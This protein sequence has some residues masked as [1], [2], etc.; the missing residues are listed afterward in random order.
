MKLIVGLGNPGREYSNTR[1]NIGFRAVE[2]IVN[3]NSAWSE[4]KDYLVAESVLNNQK[5]MFIKPQ[6]Y[7]NNSGQPVSEVARFFKFDP[8]E[9]L[10]V[11]D[12]VDIPYG[13]IRIKEGGG[14][15]GHNG[16]KSVTQHLGSSE[17]LRLR[18][19]VGRPEI[20]EMD[21]AD[22]VLGRFSQEEGKILP[23]FLD[24]AAAAV[25]EILMSGLKIAQNKFNSK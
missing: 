1:H 14:D 16:L 6:S 13:A 7:M 3:D 8:A 12:E 24:R 15:A 9:I 11:H 5:L 2:V 18:L 17:Y 20:P 21:T 19:G 22:W 25:N 23:D 10:V 4:K